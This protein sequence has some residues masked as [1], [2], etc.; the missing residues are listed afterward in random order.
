[1]PYKLAQYGVLSSDYSI[2][3]HSAASGCNDPP[4]LWVADWE[5]F[6]RNILCII[7]PKLPFINLIKGLLLKA[8]L[9]MLRYWFRKVIP[10]KCSFGLDIR[11]ILRAWFY[12]FKQ[13]KIYFLSGRD[14][15]NISFLVD[16]WSIFLE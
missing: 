14:N 7:S 3:I 5:I 12:L 2:W 11:N 8:Q 4:A 13:L 15:L 1:M 10:Q 6:I 16:L 9:Y